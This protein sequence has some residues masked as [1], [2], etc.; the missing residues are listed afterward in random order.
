MTGTT[1]EKLEQKTDIHF[2]QYSTLRLHPKVISNNTVNCGLKCE[3][4][5]LILHAENTLIL[6]I[7]ILLQLWQI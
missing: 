5:I 3:T 2:P 7:W 1:K 4:S 6:Q